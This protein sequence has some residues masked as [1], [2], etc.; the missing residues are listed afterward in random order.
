[1][2]VYIT[3]KGDKMSNNITLKYEGYQGIAL[4]RFNIFSLRNLSILYNSP[5]RDFSDLDSKL[6]ELPRLSLEEVKS[7]AQE[8]CQKY[9]SSHNIFVTSSATLQENQHYISCSKTGE[10]FYQKVNSFLREISPF[11]ININLIEGHAMVGYIYKPLFIFPNCLDTKNRKVY[12]EYMALG[13]DLNL[14]SV[15]TFVHEF[16]H[17]Q[18][19]QN[20]GY[21]AD[22]LNKEVISIFLEKVVALE[23]DPSGELLKLSERMR[24]LDLFYKYGRIISQGNTLT[25][26]EKNDDLVYVK[27]ILI[28]EKL[29]DMYQKERKPKNKDK[30]ISDIQS[31]FDGQQ[32]VEDIIGRRN[33]NIHQCQDLLLLKRHLDH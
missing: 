8:F 22:Y 4:D 9:F 12:Y 16:A 17:S 14:L 26:E 2:I 29:F 3:T 32:T 1:M 27:S 25:T 30:Y 19:E 18:Q 28:A 5:A 21:C 15:G 33:I 6:N 7:L 11:A 24:F 13:K 23:L 20:I 31:V 10:E